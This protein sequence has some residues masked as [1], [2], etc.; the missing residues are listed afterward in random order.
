MGTTHPTGDSHM[1]KVVEILVYTLKQ[2]SGPEFYETM[3][4]TSVPLH[5]E[6]EI[7]VVWHGPSLHCADGYILI[8][9]FK[10]MPS[11]EASQDRFYN[12]AA[13][14]LGPREAII[15]KIEKSMKAVVEMPNSAVDAIR[16][17]GYLP[18]SREKMG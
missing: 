3:T 18:Q 14:R 17:S 8:R 4:D 2:G 6:N 10:D 5:L 13:W 15:S 11:L 12:S 16:K 1:V 7:D 9:A